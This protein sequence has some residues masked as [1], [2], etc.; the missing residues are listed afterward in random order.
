MTVYF[1]L[2]PPNS[3]YATALFGP[4]NSVALSESPFT[5]AVRTQE[6]PRQRWRAQIQ[7]IDRS[8][9]GQ[10]DWQGF[11]T[12]LRGRRGI[13]LLGDPLA[14]APLGSAPGTPLVAAAHPSGLTLAT[15]GWTPSQ[16]NILKRGDL[17]Q[18]GVG[19][20]ARLYMVTA[21][22]AS[23]GGGASTLDIWPSWRIATASAAQIMTDPG[24]ETWASSSDLTNW[25]EVGAGTVGTFAQ[26]TPPDAGTYSLEIARTGGSSMDLALR[27]A[28]TGIRPLEPYRMTLR[29]KASGAL[30]NGL[31]INIIVGGMRYQA[32]TGHYWI[33]P[34]GSVFTARKSLTTSWQTF[35]V[36]FFG[37]PDTTTSSSYTFDI[38]HNAGS[39]T[40]VFL[41]EINVTGPGF[42]DWP[43]VTTSPVGV[44]RLDDN[45]IQWVEAP[46][47]RVRIPAFSAVS[48]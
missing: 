33:T 32:D 34:G 45:S 40:S 4:E 22:A 39:G 31:A 36:L 25:T 29:A 35:E 46:P 28:K 15:D 47:S 41:D 27:Q 16:S 10:A 2:T 30:T 44:F 20:I 11:L 18:V 26:S 43:I 9:S 12:A 5:G 17:F 37:A 1:P 19:R 38:H 7:V 14:T 8:R 48:L 23:D 42:D 6:W 3:N 21:A 13:F 24:L